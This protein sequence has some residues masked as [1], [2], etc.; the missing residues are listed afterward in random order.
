MTFPTGPPSHCTLGAEKWGASTQQEHALAEPVGCPETTFTS[1]LERPHVPPY[2]LRSAGLCS[3]S[4]WIHPRVPRRKNYLPVINVIIFTTPAPVIV[5][6]PIDLCELL[7]AQGRHTSKILIVRQPGSREKSTLEKRCQPKG[8]PACLQR[9]CCCPS[10]S[11]HAA[12]T[13][14]KAP[15]CHRKKPCVVVPW[16]QLRERELMGPVPEKYFANGSSCS[17]LL[18]STLSSKGRLKCISPH[19]R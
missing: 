13:H 17:L 7:F 3:S 12:S 15:S 11:P 14:C 6:E 5:R 4:P 2:P 16:T 9:A 8:Q 1:C 18:S 19:R 10:P